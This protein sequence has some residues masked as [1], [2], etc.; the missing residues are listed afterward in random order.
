MIFSK[1]KWK[2]FIKFVFVSG[3]SAI[4]NLIFRYIFNFW[5]NYSFSIFFAY[6][7]STTIAF[8]FDKIFVFNKAK[9][10]IRKQIFF[11]I[12]VNL[13]GLALTLIISNLFVFLF[14]K[15]GFYYFMHE[16]AH[17]MGLGST[18]FTSYF[19]HKYFSFRNN[20]I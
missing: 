19:G 2:Q 15:I 1:V 13:C 8:I 6:I 17:F 12:L 3:C 11:F 5:V 4:F 14:E 16:I 18:S 10:H 7:I 9:Q 20:E